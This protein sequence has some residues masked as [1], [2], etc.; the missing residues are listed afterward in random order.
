MSASLHWTSLC[1]R[2]QCR[3]RWKTLRHYLYIWNGVFISNF[4]FSFILFVI[5]SWCAWPDWYVNQ[6]LNYQ[7]FVIQTRSGISHRP[8]L[9]PMKKYSRQPILTLFKKKHTLI[10]LGSWVY[11]ISDFIRFLNLQTHMKMTAF[12]DIA[13]CSLV[14]L[15]RRFRG[16]FGIHHQSPW[17]WWQ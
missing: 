15:K 8:Q 10:S 16:A 5:L 13:P 9:K 4:S 3:R 6:H 14:V 11:G 17:C 2:L 12:W 1:R 7:H